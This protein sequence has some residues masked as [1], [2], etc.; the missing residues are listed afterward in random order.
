MKKTFSILTA[1]VLFMTPVSALTDKEAREIAEKYVPAGSTYVETETE[2]GKSEV[3]FVKGKYEYEVTVSS[4]G[5]VLEVEKD[6]TKKAGGRS[7]VLTKKEAMAKVK[8]AFKGAKITDIE[9]KKT[10]KD[11]CYYEIEFK[12]SAYRGE[13]KVNAE[14]GKITEYEKKYK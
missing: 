1:A 6:C 5:K 12:T 2:H 3:E 4:R 11:G 8:K 9:K 10:K 13:A 14:T 7:F